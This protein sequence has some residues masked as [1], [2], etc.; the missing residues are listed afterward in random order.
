VSGKQPGTLQRFPLEHAGNDRLAFVESTRRNVDVPE[1][2]VVHCSLNGCDLRDT[3]GTD[4]Q[5]VFLQL[6]R[7]TLLVVDDISALY[8][9]LAT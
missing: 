1:H 8:E 3:S 9:R 7:N 6:T 2:V 4:D 5:Y